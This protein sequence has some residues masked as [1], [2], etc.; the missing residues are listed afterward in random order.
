MGLIATNTVAQGDTREV[1]LDRMVDS[2]FTITRAIQSRSWP[3]QSVNLEFSAVWGT[4][5]TV[6]SRVTMVCDDKLVSRISS[7]LEPASRAEREPERLVENAGAAFVGCY[8]LGRGFVLEPEEA[9]EWIAADPRNADVLFPYLNGD[10]LNSRPDCSASRWVID[11]NNWPEGRAAEYKAPYR[12]LLRCV[13]PERQRVKPDGSYVLRR[14]L[15]ERW[16]QYADKRPAMRE[17]I[18]DLDEVLVIAQVSRTLMPVRVLNRSVFDA[19][20]VV[21]ALNSSSDQAVLSSSIHQMW[22]VK[23]GTTRRVDPNIYSDD[24]V[25]DLPTAQTHAGA[26]GHRPHLGHRAARNHAAPR[27]RP[28]ETLQPRQ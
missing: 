12:H 3:S 11:F 4:R 16:W 9:Q 10:D 20:L 18:A 24:C 8:V 15:P 17:A 26:G 21:F 23:F 7:L 27:P 6:S 13:K 1:G 19:K 28:H 5:D 25:R 2:G 22:A 14:P